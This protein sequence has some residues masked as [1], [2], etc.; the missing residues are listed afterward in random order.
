M[1]TIIPS[2]IGSTAFWNS[3]CKKH[4]QV[5]NK[6]NASAGAVP[7]RAINVISSRATIAGTRN[8]SAVAI[9]SHPIFLI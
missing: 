3:R 2:A 5:F 1:M 4:N 6:V 8:I 9:S 7:K